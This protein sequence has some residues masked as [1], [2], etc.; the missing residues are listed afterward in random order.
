METVQR[1]NIKDKEWKGNELF[2]YSSLSVHVI[3]FRVVFLGI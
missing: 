2:E 3:L 1:G